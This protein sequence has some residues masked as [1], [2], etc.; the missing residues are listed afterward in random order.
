MLGPH[1][2]ANVEKQHVGGLRLAKDGAQALLGGQCPT[3]VT[4]PPA[5]GR[6]IDILPH[7]LE[8]AP[9]PAVQVE[10]PERPHHRLVACLNHAALEIERI[11]G[12]CDLLL[13]DR[14]AR[15]VLDDGRQ[16]KGELARH[17]VSERKDAAA[18]QALRKRLPGTWRSEWRHFAVARLVAPRAAGVRPRAH[19]RPCAPAVAR[20]RGGSGG[21]GSMRI[22]RCRCGRGRG[23]RPRL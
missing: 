16:L 4:L 18:C 8:A 12:A 2:N 20:T 22:R 14:H 5:L 21:S 17:G 6:K 10:K 3:D 11:L 15:Q 13:S 7:K 1:S 23:G 19:N 9:R